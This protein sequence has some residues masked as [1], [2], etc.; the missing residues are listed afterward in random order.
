MKKSDEA[1]ELFVRGHY[2]CDN[3][4][5]EWG[6]GEVWEPFENYREEQIEEWMDNDVRSLKQFL[7]EEEHDR[8]KESE[9]DNSRVRGWDKRCN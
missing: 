3:D 5:G 6:K 1:I 9:I 2:Y 8:P 7:E 4:S